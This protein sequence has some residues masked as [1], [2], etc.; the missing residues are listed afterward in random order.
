MASPSLSRSMLCETR[1]LSARSKKKTRYSAIAMRQR[2]KIGLI[3]CRRA[4]PNLV[5]GARLW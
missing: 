5:S 3:A 4:C 2:F 1:T